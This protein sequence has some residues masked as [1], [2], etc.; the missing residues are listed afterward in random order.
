MTRSGKEPFPA[1]S[2]AE[3]AERAAAIL[4]PLERHVLGLSARDKLRNAAIT[5]S[6]AVAML[7]LK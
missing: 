2:D 7:S 4:S 6:G 5:R 1:S 3:G